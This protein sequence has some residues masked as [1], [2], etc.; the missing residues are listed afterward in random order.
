MMK[1]SKGLEMFGIVVR[2]QDASIEG[3]KVVWLQFKDIY[4]VYQLDA[5]NTVLMIAWCM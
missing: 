5:L 4:E 2:P 1:S 3:E